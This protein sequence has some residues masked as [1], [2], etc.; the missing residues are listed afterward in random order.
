MQR[1]SAFLAMAA[2]CL[3]ISGCTSG[4]GAPPVART[5]NGMVSGV[6]DHG[7]VSWKGIPFAAPPVGDLRWRAPSTLR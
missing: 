5:G 4:L 2:T 7:V 3:A 6:A 1:F